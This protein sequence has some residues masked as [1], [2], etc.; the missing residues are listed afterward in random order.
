MHIYMYEITV[1]FVKIEVNVFFL[2]HDEKTFLV[3]SWDLKVIPKKIMR[4]KIKGSQKLELK[5][6]EHQN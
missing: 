5:V 3:R 2:I 1:L 4:S 6:V